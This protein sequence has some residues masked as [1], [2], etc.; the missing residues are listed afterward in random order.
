VD[1]I[2]VGSQPDNQSGLEYVFAG[3]LDV[4]ECDQVV[5]HQM[6]LDHE[7]VITTA[8]LDASLETVV[9]L[10]FQGEVVF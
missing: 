8:D 6:S 1:T 2:K 4:S 5:V 7:G 10:S 9:S 3:K